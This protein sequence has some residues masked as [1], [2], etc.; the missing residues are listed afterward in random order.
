[1]ATYLATYLM[2]ALTALGSARRN[3]GPFF[4]LWGIFLVWFM[5]FRFETGCDYFGYLNRWENFSLPGNVPDLLRG[6]EIGFTLLIASV[7]VLGL[8]YTWLNAF[9]SAILVFCYVRFARAH[10]FAPVILA[11]LF[12][13]VII[14]L[15]MSGLRQALAG[16]F[17]M[18]SFNAFARGSRAWTAIWV[19]VGMQFHASAVIF[20]PIAL[21]AG[22]EVNTVRLMLAMIVAG[23][24]AA[25]LIADRFE[26]YE[27]RY[28]EGNVTSG[29][30]LIRY[31]LCLLPVPV[32]LLYRNRLKTVFPDAFPLLKLALLILVALAPLVVLSSIALHRLNY[33]VMPLSILLCIYAGALAFRRP[34]HGLGFFAL[35]YGTYSFL[36]FATSKHADY[37]YVP[38]ENTWLM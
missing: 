27:A 35:A 19:L 4:L 31:A 32:A 28:I 34:S 23:P 11:L 8:D 29:G 6:E 30:A 17:L 12:P 38:Y 37:C 26:T 16:A 5:G 1:M 22:R 14:Q 13:V 21:I 24:V 2:L 9:A 3:H 18:L 20:L 7:K 10:P 15:G 25:V 33:Y 36:W